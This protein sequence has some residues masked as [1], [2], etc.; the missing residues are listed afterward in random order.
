MSRLDKM[1]YN[2]E[3]ECKIIH[4]TIEHRISQFISQTDN[5]IGNYRKKISSSLASIVKII[6]RWPREEVNYGLNKLQ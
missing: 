4:L 5:K 3:F 1:I 2:L 6:T